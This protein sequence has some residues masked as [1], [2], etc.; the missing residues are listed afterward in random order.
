MFASFVIAFAMYSRIPMPRREWTEKNMRYAICFFPWIGAVIGLLEVGF[1]H[2]CGSLQLGSWFR[3]VGLTVI[4]V[5]V[6]GGIHLDGFLDTVDARS[7]HAERERKLEILKDSHTGAFAILGGIVYFLLTSGG[8]SE[9]RGE[10]LGAVAAG[11][12]LSRSYSG[13]AV[14]SFRQARKKGM[15]ASF[16]EQAQKRQVRWVMLASI[17]A[18]SAFMVVLSPLYGGLA[19]VTALAVFGYYRYFSYR[20]FG[21]ATGDLAGYFV[22]ICELSI[23]LVLVLAER[24]VNCL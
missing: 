1:W 6:T 19:A 11:F 5:A 10:Q 22:Q 18:C 12:F 13:L 23:L 7:S 4:P 3:T 9:L 8:W 15:M 21:G 17:L 16:A 2:L 24:V 14:V 20:E